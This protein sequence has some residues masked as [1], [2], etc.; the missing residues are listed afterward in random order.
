MAVSGEKASDEAAPEGAATGG[1][2][3]GRAEAPALAVRGLTVRA[4]GRVLVE[5]VT[6]AV[7]PGEVFALL[8][9]NGA[10]K[11]T[12]L[13]AVLGLIRPAA[14]EVWLAGRKLWPGR[15][16]ALR[17]VGGLIEAPAV[18]PY[19]TG[20]DHLK[21]VGRM[22]GVFDPAALY[23]LAERTGIAPHLSARVATY[24]LGMRQRLALALALVGRPAVVVLDEPMNGLDP[25]GM[26]D[27]RMFIRELAAEGQA[28]LFS[29]HLLAEVE[30]VAD[31]IGLMAGGRL[32]WSRSVADVRRAAGR[33]YRMVLRPPE[34]GEALLRAAPEVVRLEPVPDAPP[35]TVWVWLADETKAPALIARLAG[36]GV[37]VRAAAPDVPPL[38]EL[39]FAW[40]EA[41]GQ[42]YPRGRAER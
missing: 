21:H 35:G 23:A 28:V 42:A 9:P 29:S 11:T 40:T 3:F 31:R 27:F 32:L 26:R 38:Q 4:G 16:S 12:T 34:A 22:R 36:A 33:R 14:G 10:G 5:D 20:W 15:P 37:E 41:D 39:F 19:L 18:Y 2:G 24:S 30:A 7:R 1:A 25:P 8:G 17:A 6:F 13:R